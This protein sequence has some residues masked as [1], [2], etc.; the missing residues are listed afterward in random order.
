ME[1][2]VNLRQRRNRRIKI[3]I[4]L[5]IIFVLVVILTKFTNIYFTIWY[6]SWAFIFGALWKKLGKK[7]LIAFIPIVRWFYLFLAVDQTPVLII[8]CLI[9]IVNFIGI[10][11]V[12]WIL[13]KIYRKK[14]KA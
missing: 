13:C 7:Q 14:L 10:P 12:L 9:P 8:F 4:A 2:F 3:A 1:S 5:A 6:F 11:K